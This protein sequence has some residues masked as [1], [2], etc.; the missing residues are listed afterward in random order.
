MELVKGSKL[1]SEGSKKTTSLLIKDHRNL[2]NMALS[3]SAATAFSIVCEPY[4]L[5]LFIIIYA[6][7][8]IG[9]FPIVK[10]RYAEINLIKNLQ[11]RNTQTYKE[12][13]EEYDKVIKETASLIRRLGLNSSKEICVFIGE[14]INQGYLS[15]TG[16]NQFKNHI[17]DK[18]RYLP[19]LAGAKVLTGACVCRHYA[20]LTA[21]ILTELG[22]EACNMR[23][24]QITSDIPLIQFVMNPL[25]NHMIVGV[26][27]DGQK[28]TYDP[29]WR[30]LGTKDESISDYNRQKN[31]I[32]KTVQPNSKSYGFIRKPNFMANYS[33]EGLQLKMH[34]SPLETITLEE[35]IALKEKIQRII[36]QHEYDIAEFAAAN[37]PSIIRTSN[38]YQEL[39]PSSDRPIKKWLIRK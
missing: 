28:Y 17:F 10:Q 13:K 24:T 7:N 32:L 29:T 31:N 15:A 22:Y 11:F 23:V 35:S 33:K 37:R 5:L 6:Y 38:L 2:K 36:E 14:L 25:P 34:S 3:A 19:E 8:L 20:P 39:F 1:L 27:E 21:D 12:C 26:Y 30:C 18:E 16:K 9:L 4:T